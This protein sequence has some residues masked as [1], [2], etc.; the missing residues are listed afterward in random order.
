MAEQR[1]S[2]EPLREAVTLREAIDRLFQDSFVRPSGAGPTTAAAGNL[3]IDLYETPDNY[4]LVASLPGF[5]PDDV[6]ITVHGEVLSIRAEFKNA[7]APKDAQY[8]VR[9]RRPGSLVRQLQLPRAVVPDKADADFEN[10]V[11]RLT[12]P[13]AESEKPRTIKIGPRQNNN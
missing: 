2:W 13:K 9:E 8:L 11:L 1:A 10:G 12:L 7:E 6:D 3:P 4:V 5:R